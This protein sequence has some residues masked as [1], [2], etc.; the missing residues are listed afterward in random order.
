[1]N[2]KNK[3]TTLVAFRLRGKTYVYAFDSKK[4]AQAFCRE[5]DKRRIDWSIGQAQEVTAK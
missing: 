1:M 4:N 3:P 5:C 2:S